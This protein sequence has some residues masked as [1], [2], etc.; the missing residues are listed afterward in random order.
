MSE[1]QLS[2]GSRGGGGGGRV[3]IPLLLVCPLFKSSAKLFFYYFWLS[4][5]SVAERAFLSLQSTGS[6]VRGLQ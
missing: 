6:G 4:R 1:L 3:L 2:F 5:V